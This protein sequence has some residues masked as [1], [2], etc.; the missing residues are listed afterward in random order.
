[1]LYFL[2]IFL[3]WWFNIIK[4]NYFWCRVVKNVICLMFYKYIIKNIE[5][6]VI[7]KYRNMIKKLFLY[8]W[9]NLFKIV[10]IFGKWS[11]FVCSL[12]FF[13][14]VSLKRE[15]LKEYV[16]KVVFFKILMNLVVFFISY[17]YCFYIFNELLLVFDEF[18][19]IFLV[20]L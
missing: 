16:N 14:V 15:V 17:R 20:C 19:W 4:N 7:K 2:E 6:L 11:I 3:F 18:Y 10:Y 8:F 9:N 12:E 5:L 1:M 13:C